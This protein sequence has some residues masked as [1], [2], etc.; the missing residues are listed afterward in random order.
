MKHIFTTLSQK[1]PEYLIEA[2]VIVASILGAF[3]LDN[4]N[5]DRKLGQEKIEFVGQLIAN[6]ESNFN[7]LDQKIKMHEAL[8]SS[9]FSILEDFDNPA[10][11]RKDKLF[12]NLRIMTV[13]PTF[14][15]TSQ[16]L[17]LSDKMNLIENSDL[18]LLLTN[19]NSDITALRELE[20]MYQNKAYNHF[21]PYLTDLG[22]YRDV[23]SH[24]WDNEDFNNEW[25]LGR[26]RT[27]KQE[28]TKSKNGKDPSF[29]LSDR[30][31]E[32]M[33]S[34]GILLNQSSLEQAYALKIKIEK[35]IDLLQQEKNK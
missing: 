20:M 21:V 30:K 8:V 15:P 16:D 23:S 14:D 35:T 4:W 5:E 1:W 2:I 32:G 33:I 11:M 17:Q 22:I 26:E 18:K 9:G 19:W 31:L 3:A 34:E 6:Y 29:V 24:M 12:N 13:D 25:L 27:L 28:I 7:Q 10:E